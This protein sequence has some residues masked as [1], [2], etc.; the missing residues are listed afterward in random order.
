MSVLLY[1]PTGSPTVEPEPTEP[2]LVT[3]H[4]AVSDTV[5]I[6]NT[7]TNEEKTCTT[8]ATGVGTIDLYPDT[9]YEF[10]SDKASGLDGTGHYS[11]TV[12]V[13]EI[14]PRLPDGYKELNYIESSGTQYIDTGVVG[15]EKVSITYKAQA[16]NYYGGGSTNGDNALMLGSRNSSSVVGLWAKQNSTDAFCSFGALTSANTNI[17]VKGINTYT[18]TNGNFT[19][20]GVSVQLSTA[21]SFTTD[22]SILIFKG[23]TSNGGIDSRYLNQRVYFVSIKVDGV[24][25]CNLIPCK[26]LSDNAIGMYDLVTNAFFGNSGTG[27]FISGGEINTTPQIKVMPDKTAFWYGNT[28][29]SGSDMFNDGLTSDSI[30]RAL[31]TVDGNYL[32]LKYDV[33]YREYIYVTS[34]MIN[35]TGCSKLI[36]I[37]KEQGQSIEFDISSVNDEHYVLF[38]SYRNPDV[39][40]NYLMQLGYT[41]ALYP[42]VCSLANKVATLGWGVKW[43]YCKAIYLE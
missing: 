35:F 26:R 32:A 22:N 28:L 41:D 3:I 19:C 43:D 13:T 25:T 34:N 21:S 33:K 40:G 42:T 31:L 4:S 7:E 38:Y 1:L 29:G 14:E 12:T 2:I 16:L 37:G 23:R 8:D 10:T 27:D 9:E 11:K 15:T 24:L 6:K 36:A 17:D 18:I 39:T 30:T 20:N 5:T